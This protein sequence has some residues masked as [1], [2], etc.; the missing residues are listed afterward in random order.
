MART[1]EVG[2]VGVG[3]WGPKL[4]RNLYDTT[5]ADLTWVIDRDLSRLERIGQQ[6]PRVQVSDRYDDLLDSSAEAVVIATPIRTHHALAK[7]A[8]L[9]GKHVMIEK[10]LAASSAECEELIEIADARGLTLMVGHT[11]EYNAAIRSLRRIV[12]SGDLGDVF[13]VD[14]ARLN[15]GLFQRDI[16]VIWDLAP[17]DLSIL[18]HVLQREPLAV[19]ARGGAHI[20]YGVHDVVFLELLFPDN[21]LANVHLSW[22][23]PRKERRVTIVGSKKMLV[24]DDVQELEKIHI[25]DKGVDLPTRREQLPHE[26]DEFFDFHLSYRYGDVSIPYV[27]FAEPLRTQ[28]EHFLECIRTGQQPLTDGREGLTVVRLIEAANRSL[29]DGGRR[30][31]VGDGAALAGVGANVADP[32]AFGTRWPAGLAGAANGS[33]AHTRS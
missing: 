19:S 17:H 31:F 32:A 27:P 33:A 23:Y 15:L 25:Y 14:T 7:A 18:L 22:L 5:S 12:E 1:V 9:R 8:L 10:P 6:Y 4:V 2:V 3:Y 16:N 29:Q 11:F 20:H 24:C 30:I 28:C 21:I 13:Y 26:T